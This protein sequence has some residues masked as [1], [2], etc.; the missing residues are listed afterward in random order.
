MNIILVCYMS[1]T[2]CGVG[3]SLIFSEPVD[4]I[5][6]NN[7]SPICSY[8]YSFLLP[9]IALLTQC[10]IWRICE[11]VKYRWSPFFCEDLE[12][13]LSFLRLLEWR[14]R[15]K[16]FRER[17]CVFTPSFRAT[18]VRKEEICPVAL[19]DCK[20]ICHFLGGVWWSFPFPV[21]VDAG[22][23]LEFTWTLTLDFYRDWIFWH[24]CCYPYSAIVILPLFFLTL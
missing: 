16:N 14:G 7:F 23:N 9:C 3:W 19:R 2:L 21:A 12:F 24:L 15:N 6:S 5:F 1:P 10:S 8:C 22:E 13:S 17:C 18:L 11:D 20:R 4:F